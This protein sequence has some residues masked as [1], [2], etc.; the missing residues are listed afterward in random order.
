V[1]VENRLEEKE[2]FRMDPSIILVDV[3]DVLAMNA[4]MVGSKFFRAWTAKYKYSQKKLTTT[5]PKSKRLLT[6]DLTTETM[7]D[8]PPPLPP[9]TPQSDADRVR[10]S[11]FHDF[12]LANLVIN[13]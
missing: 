11:L 8:A 13:S 10:T 7:S 12:L 4:D 2:E 5:T 1:K 6:H 9:P 3:L